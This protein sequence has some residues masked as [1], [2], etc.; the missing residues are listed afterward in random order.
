MYI[1][2][3]VDIDVDI[4]RPALDSKKSEHGCKVIYAGCPSSFGLGLE[5]GQIP[6][7]WLRLH[8]GPNMECYGTI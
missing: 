2:V 5:D 8:M 7:F 4:D 3:Y 6:T 1:C